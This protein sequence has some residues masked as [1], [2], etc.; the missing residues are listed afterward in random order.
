MYRQMLTV[1][2]AAGMALLPVLPAGAQTAT[3]CTI[4]GTAGNDVMRGTAG[5]D[6]ICGLGGDDTIEGL[7]G[8]DTLLGG[9]GND[10]LDGGPGNDRL[11]GSTGNDRLRGGTGG[12][13]IL[14]GDGTDV[15]GADAGDDRLDGGR[16]NDTLA[17]GEGNDNVAGGIGNDRLAGDA[18]S[19]VLTPG[20]GADLCQPGDPVVGTCTVDNTGPV[21]SGFSVP[22]VVQAGQSVTFTWRL[23]DPAG[24]QNAGVTIGWAP[25]LY[26]GCGFAQSATLV[27]GTAT[28]GQWSYTCTFPQNAV[29]TEYSAQVAT[30]DNFGNYATSEWGY[31]RI[32]GPN[33]DADPP[34][35]TGPPTVGTARI[36]DP[37]TI[38]WTLTDASEINGAFMWVAG[39]GGYGFVDAA[40]RPYAEY[41]SPVDQQCN[42]ERTT[43]TFT[44]TV[45]LSPYGTPGTWTLWLSAA[46]I[47]ANK[48]FA[49][50]LSFPVLGP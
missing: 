31:F 12:D 7:G 50:V 45:R 39:T 22:A 16:G 11:D 25:G 8:D 27:A 36:G 3:P 15:L 40:G 9:P 29:A 5:N 37:L 41:T 4:T 21:V 44:Q 46:D 30:I 17:G 24:V 26:T 47:S 6:V 14:G 20:S 19:D 49:A 2:A 32:D 18:G 1:L 48:M 28:D 43:C 10:T 38:S 13:R 42:A 23:V 34:A 33:T 35:L